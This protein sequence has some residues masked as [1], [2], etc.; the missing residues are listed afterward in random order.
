MAVAG[1]VRAC[2]PDRLRRLAALLLGI[3]LALAGIAVGSVPAAAHD[4]V[5]GVFAAARSATPTMVVT[6]T[7]D[8]NAWLAHDTSASSPA[9]AVTPGPICWRPPSTCGT[10]AHSLALAV[11]AEGRAGD[12]VSGLSQ[13]AKNRLAGQAFGENVAS[14][15]AS[16]TDFNVVGQQVGVKTPFGTRVMDIL[17][18]RNDS[19][20]NFEIKRGGSPYGPAQRATDA[21]M[22]RVG[23]D[24]GDGTR[25]KI[26]TVVIRGPLP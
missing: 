6:Y 19:L 18:E 4:N 1:A 23:V 25:T 3:L 22:A 2:H 5:G 10:S 11:A 20:V 26:P 16:E 21:Y 24:L 13:L 9:A 15:L 7:F 17:A 12:A 8:S 14:R